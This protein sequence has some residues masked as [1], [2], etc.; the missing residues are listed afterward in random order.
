MASSIGRAATTVMGK[1]FERHIQS[2]GLALTPDGQTLYWTVLSGHTLWRISTAL[3]RDPSMDERALANR[4]ERVDTIE[5]TDGLLFDRQ[6]QLW[7]GGLEHGAL[8]RFSPESRKY[9][10]VILDPRLRWPDTFAQGPEGHIYV[11]T[12]QIHLP[13]AERGPYEIYR[14]TP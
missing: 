9:E 7:L 4:P 5:A 1:A 2:D 3:L 10:Q 6:G 11:T 14:F 12:S 13:P 8:Y